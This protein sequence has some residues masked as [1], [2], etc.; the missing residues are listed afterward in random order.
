[1]ICEDNMTSC[2]A[3]WKFWQEAPSK[4]GGKTWQACVYKIRCISSAICT[5]VEKGLSSNT[6]RLVWASR[7]SQSV[8]TSQELSTSLWQTRMSFTEG[9]MRTC[10]LLSLFSERFAISV[11]YTRNK[12]LPIS[13][14]NSFDLLLMLPGDVFC[15]KH[16]RICLTYLRPSTLSTLLPL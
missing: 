6:S 15:R 8:L 13:C 9:G 2:Q 1:M 3:F 4:R 12:N 5:D 7:D 10:A 16:T 11:W 14:S